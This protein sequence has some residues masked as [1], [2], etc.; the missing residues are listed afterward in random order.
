MLV[1]EEE[2]V[3]TGMERGQDAGE[4]VRCE[5]VVGRDV[6]WERLQGGVGVEWD[7]DAGEGIDAIEKGWVEGEAEFG[8]RAELQGVVRIVCGEHSGGG[9]GGFDERGAAIEHGDAEATMVEF[10]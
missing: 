8:E 10:E 5:D 6:R 2:P 4:V 9:G 7:A 1:E 3:V